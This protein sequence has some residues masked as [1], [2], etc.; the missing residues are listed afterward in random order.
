MKN[1]SRY[2]LKQIGIYFYCITTSWRQPSPGTASLVSSRYQVPSAFL[3]CH[4]YPTGLSPHGH[5]KAA[6][7]YTNFIQGR[8]KR[9]KKN[10]SSPTESDLFCQVNEIFPRTYPLSYPNQ[11]HWLEFW[12][13]ATVS[14]K[15]GWEMEYKP[16]RRRALGMCVGQPSSGVCHSS[17]AWGISVISKAT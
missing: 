6:A 9:G 4:P 10:E 14:W 5:K 15:G 2:Q 16:T 3:C 7:G 1:L 17:P 13:I 8:M 11:P 12:Q